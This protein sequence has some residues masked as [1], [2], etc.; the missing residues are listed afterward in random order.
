MWPVMEGSH[1][2]LIVS[3]EDGEERIAVTVKMRESY[4]TQVRNSAFSEQCVSSV[5]LKNKKINSFNNCVTILYVKIYFKKY[6]INI[7]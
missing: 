6:I 4:A 5:R 1:V 3:I 7:N 2:S